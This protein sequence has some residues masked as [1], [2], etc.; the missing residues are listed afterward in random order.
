MAESG[1]VAHYSSRTGSV[2]DR[3]TAAAISPA[4]TAI[5]ENVGNA[6]SAADAEHGFMAS[7]GHRDNILNRTLTHVGI[8]V[9]VGHE[10]GGMVSLYFTQ[11]FA[12]WGQ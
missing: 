11:V 1:E 3:V 5:A 9:A 4:P 12:G 10:T 6:L 2:V 8:G 7:P